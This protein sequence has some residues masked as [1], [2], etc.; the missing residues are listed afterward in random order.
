MRLPFVLS[1]SKNSVTKNVPDKKSEKPFFENESFTK[2]ANED[3]VKG[4]TSGESYDYGQAFNQINMLNG[5]PL[6]DLG[7][8]G[9]GMTI[10]VLDAGFLNANV[11]S[12]FDSLWLN[13]QI[14]GYKDFV[15]PLAP[16]IFG[17]HTHGTSVLS[18]MG[19]NLPAE[20]VGTAP[21]ADYW[22]LRSED[23]ATEYLIEEL[24]WASAAE[25]ADSVGV[26]VINSSLVYNTFDDPAQDH[27]YAYMDGN[28]T[29]I[30]IAADL[31]ASKGILVVNSA[32]NSGSSSWHY[33]GAPADG[34]SVFSIGAVNSSGVYASFSSTGP[35][36][37]GRIKPNVVAQGQGSTIIS[38]YSGNVI[39]GNG[40]SFSSP[41]TAGMVASLWQAHPDKKNTEI[42]E[43]IQQSATQALNPDS[44]LGFGIPDYFAA[45]TLL[46]VPVIHIINLDIKVFLEGPF[47]G[48]DMN[49]DLNAILPLN[50]PYN[51]PP[52]NYTGMEQVDD[53]PGMDVVD[54]ILVELR[55]AP[56]AAEATGGTIVAQAAGFI[57][58][59][60]TITDTTGTN[61]L[62]FNLSITDSLY[63]VIHHRNHIS[64][65]S[66]IAIKEGI[67][68]SWSY[69]FTTAA[70]KALGG[71]AGFKELMIGVFAMVTGDGNA[72]GLI[73]QLDK[74][75]EWEGN[76]GYMEYHAAD[77][78][79]DAQ[80]DN[81][82]KDD[83]WLPNMVFVGQ[84]PE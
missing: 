52:F 57:K 58:S 37:D 79:C 9:A 83:F 24:N 55:D 34:D 53:I 69:D 6:H 78:N 4:V 17:S 72:D 51:L 60:G 80:I 61:P 27:T 56:S 44:L 74:V 18:T 68:N 11:L 30:T 59:D 14:I 81:V 22:L 71:S 62:S 2:I 7:Y 84:V 82:D 28:T 1:V 26:D 35:T 16:D 12:A 13:N 64:V 23:D 15:S 54:W 29:P 65:M 38:A 25:Y 33:I 66:A 5:I 47:N 32:G 76:A 40:T 45:H 73:D 70:S 10:A 3:I 8:D 31:A 19:A 67:A 75:T 36:Y 49:P 42:M 20:M 77:Y 39:S 46:S 41:I 43:A 63:L 50:Q 21:K 48:V